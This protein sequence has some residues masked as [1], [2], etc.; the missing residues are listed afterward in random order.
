MCTSSPLSIL[1]QHSQ[2]SCDVNCS[3]FFLFSKRHQNYFH[4]KFAVNCLPVILCFQGVRPSMTENDLI[5]YKGRTIKLLMQGVGGGGCGVLGVG[6]W[7]LG[8]GQ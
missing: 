1:M 8:V 2:R 6:C 5:A 7:V 3:S 4:V